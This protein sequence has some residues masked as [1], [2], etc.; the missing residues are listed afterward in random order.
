MQKIIRLTEKYLQIPVSFGQPV[1]AALLSDAGEERMRMEVCMQ[2]EAEKLEQRAAAFVLPEIPENMAHGDMPG[3]QVQINED[4]IRKAS[5]IFPKLLPMVLSLLGEREEQKVVLS[6]CG[7]SGVGKSEIASLLSYYLKEFG[8][9]SYTLSGDNYPRRIPVY[10][11]AE[12]L[13]VFRTGAVKGMVKDGTFSQ[14]RFAVIRKFQIEG[15]DEDAAHCAEYPWYGSYLAGGRAALDAYL[16]SDAEIDF[17]EL[18]EIV[19]AF[20]GGQEEIWL[21]RMGRSEDALWYEKVDF[22]EVHVLV[23]EWT[24]GNSD[25]YQGVDIPVLLNSTPE[26]TLA[27]R[28]AHGRDGGTDSPFTMMVLALEQEKLKKQARKAKLIV[29]KQ[30]ELLSYEEFCKK[31]EVKEGGEAIER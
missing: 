31:M 28:A 24:H 19:A 18:E 1:R 16:G 26:E 13:R 9:G 4:H 14:E 21:K 8:I 27:H 3:D 20:K 29:S 2:L 10:N 15:S 5:V 17:Q 11:D 12:R 22:R 25:C 6:V 23:I 7:G 30:G